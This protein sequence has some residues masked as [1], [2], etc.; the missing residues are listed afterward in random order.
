MIATCKMNLMRKIINEKETNLECVIN[1]MHNINFIYSYKNS[2]VNAKLELL[3]HK[4][5]D[6]WASRRLA[7]C[8]LKLGSR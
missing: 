8:I 3:P 5:K 1:T 6:V 4:K 7:P 2:N